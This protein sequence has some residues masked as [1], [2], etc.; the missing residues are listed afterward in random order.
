MLWAFSF[1]LDAIIITKLTDII[2]YKKSK[3]L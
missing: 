1:S 3:K 2:N